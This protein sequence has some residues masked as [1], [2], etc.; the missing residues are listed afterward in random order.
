MRLLLGVAILVS[1]SLGL[2][3]A[4]VVGTTV[5][6]GDFKNLDFLVLICMSD[7]LLTGKTRTFESCLWT[8]IKSWLAL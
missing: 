6:S 5:V 3:V 4:S 7:L 8:A 2:G 1:C